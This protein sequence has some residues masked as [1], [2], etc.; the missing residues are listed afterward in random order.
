MQEEYSYSGRLNSSIVSFYRDTLTVLRQPRL[1]LR[2]LRVFQRQR[3]AARRR[4]QHEAAGTHI[5]PFLIFSVTNRC[6]L[7]C[8]GCYQR[9]QHRDTSEEVD[10]ATLNKI[11]AESLELGISTILLA[12]GEPL[13]HSELLETAGRY[14]QLLF[15]LFTNG[16]MINDQ[17]ITFLKKNWHIFPVF[18]ME[19]GQSE[20]D[21][22]RGEGVFQNLKTVL[23]VMQKKQ[24]F[25]GVSFTVTSENFEILTDDSYLE[26]LVK[27][28]C[29]LFFYI[30]YIPV[31]EGSDHLQLREE[32]Q[33]KLHTLMEKLRRKHKAVFITFPGDEEKYGGCLAAG[34]GFV[35]VT[36][37]GSLEPCPFAPYSDTNVKALS[38]REALQSD[39]L[40]A[41]RENHDLLQEHNGSCALRENRELVQQ[42]LN[43]SKP[44]KQHPDAS[45]NKP[46][47]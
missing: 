42:L 27:D 3:K 34:R 1:L 30:E 25:C 11:F 32:Q 26:E 5:P 44:A 45:C 8:T 7:R 40:Q 17:T 2:A 47:I 13:M 38:L 16:L 14:P 36:A 21:L 12:G 39:F 41:V 33:R 31:A 46:V 10:T 6:N 18:S 15:P 23:P 9:L 35:H 24:I 37:D 20:T 19:G 29:G 22:R 43:N 28:G 4:W